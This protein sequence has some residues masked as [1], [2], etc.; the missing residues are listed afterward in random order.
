MPASPG[1]PSNG[2]RAPVAPTR[3]RIAEAIR[4]LERQE[5]AL[6][7]R[8]VEVA[9]DLQL[10]VDAR[11]VRLRGRVDLEPH[12]R[13]GK[14][15]AVDDSAGL[16]VELQNVVAA[17]VDRAPGNRDRADEVLRGLVVLEAPG[18]GTGGIDSADGVDVLVQR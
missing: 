1:N 11:F 12:D 7:P 3:W 18:H 10:D 13:R 6:A 5:V 14:P 17:R 15:V 4:D 9:L 16:N 8:K 2:T